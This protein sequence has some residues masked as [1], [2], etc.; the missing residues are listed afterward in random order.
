MHSAEK[1]ISLNSGIFKCFT[2]LEKKTN[3]VHWRFIILY[4]CTV[5]FSEGFTLSEKSVFTVFQMG[6]FTKNSKISSNQQQFLVLI[7]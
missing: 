5:I 3:S 2:T 7:I 1:S 4:S 6:C